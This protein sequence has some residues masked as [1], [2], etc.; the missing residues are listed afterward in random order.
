[1]KIATWNVNSVRARLDRL[2]N[3]LPEHQPDV[4]CLQEIKVES[5]GF[6]TAPLAAL[7]YEAVVSGQRTYNGV[8]ILSKKRLEDVTAGLDDHHEDPQ[9]R[10]IAGTID[11]VRILC[12][13]MPNG[14]EVPSEKYSYKLAWMERF[15]LYLDRHFKPDQKVVLCGDLNVAPEPADVYDPVGW[16]NEPI[17]HE[18]ARKA[19]QRIE[20]FGLVDVVRKHNPNPGLYTYW[21]YRQLA[22]PKNNGLRIDHILATAPLAACCSAAVV[23]RNARKG[24]LPSDHA[25]VIAT[26]EL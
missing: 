9:A 5:A 26:F 7:G 3:W 18:D 15:R 25:P 17:F 24:K 2:L 20:Q 4:L 16:V 12:S 13:Y 22:F 1:V 8:A 10:L 21:D 11:G 23:D 19:L 14:S 6:P